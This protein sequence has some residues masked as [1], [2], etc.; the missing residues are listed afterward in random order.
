MAQRIAVVTDSN[1][2]ITQKLA[3]ELGVFVLPM[4][5]VI[6]GETF[7]ED[8]SLSQEAFYEKLQSDAAIST[9]QPAPGIFW[10]YGTRSCRITMRWCISPCPAACPDPV[11][12][13]PL[14]PRNTTAGW[15]WSIINGFPSPSASR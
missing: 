12:R 1:S 2:G 8:I 10:I 3:K 11:R 9:S 15:L 13:H 6:N 4:P 5:F 7:F 14:W